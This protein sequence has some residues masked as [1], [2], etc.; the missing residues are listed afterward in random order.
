MDNSHGRERV[1]GGVRGAGASSSVRRMRATPASEARPTVRGD[2]RS[3]LWINAIPHSWREVVPSCWTSQ[4]RGL[5]IDELERRMG[6]SAWS[7]GIGK[8]KRAEGRGEGY[9]GRVLT[10][11]AQLTTTSLINVR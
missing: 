9:T 1:G 4:K 5:A 3:G 2:G 11:R 6:A 10:S 7:L 8:V